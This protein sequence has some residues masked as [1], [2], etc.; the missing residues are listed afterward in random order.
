GPQFAGLVTARDAGGI[1]IVV[2]YADDIGGDALPSV[3]ADDRTGGVE[4]FRQVID[5]LDEMTLGRA[6]GEVRYAPGF[7]ERHPRGNT[8]MAGVALYDV[9]PLLR[10]APD[11]L[12]R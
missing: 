2:V 1:G 4:R 8:R 11:R 12:R 5:R 10:D 9:E 6:V 3:V 7:V